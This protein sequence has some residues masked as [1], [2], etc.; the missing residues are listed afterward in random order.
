VPDAEGVAEAVPRLARIRY[1]LDYNQQAW[2]RAVAPFSWGEA[3]PVEAVEVLVSDVDDV[4]LRYAAAPEDEDRGAAGW[5]DTWDNPT[6]LPAVVEAELTVGGTLMTQWFL[7]PL[8][9]GAE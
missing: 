8:A 7:V 4:A 5:S 1:Y 3:S 6:N 9:G 2:C